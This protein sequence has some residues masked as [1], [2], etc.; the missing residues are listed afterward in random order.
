MIDAT[1]QDTPLTRNIGD[2]NSVPAAIE[3]SYDQDSI[4]ILKGLEAVR[5][6]PGMYIGDT[7]ARGFRHMLSEIFDNSVDEALAGHARNIKVT[8]HADG[9]A[10]VEDDGRGIPV[11]INKEEGVAAATLALTVL[12]AGGKFEEGAYKVSGG[13]HGVGASVVNAL[14]T[15]LQM[16]IKR[17][18]GIYTQTFRDGGIYDKPLA[19]TGSTKEHGTKIHFWPDLSFF[20]DVS[21]FDAANMRDRMR[22]SSYLV[23][24]LAITFNVE[25]MNG[26]EAS[27]DQFFAAEYAEIVDH[28]AGTKFGPAVSAPLSAHGTAETNKGD[29]EVFVAMKYYDS[30]DSLVAGYANNISTPLGGQHVAGFRSALLR[31]INK[32]GEASGL[33]KEP[34]IADDVAEGLVAAIS[35]RL[36]EPRFEAQT[37]ERLTNTEASGA[38]AQITYAAISKYF[39]ENPA[40]AKGIISKA[41]IAAKAREAGRR[42]RETVT[43][44]KTVLNSTSLPGKLAD[45][46]ERNPELAELFIVEGDSAG[47]TAKMGRNSHSQ[48][49]LPLRGKILNVAKS[50]DS[51]SLKSE[52]I[53]NL[54]QAMGCGV[55]GFYNRE[56]L[57]YHKIVIMT[58]ADVDGEHIATL[59]L[60]FFHRF[61]PQL[62]EDGHVYIAM[63]P[64][65]RVKKG[66]ESHYIANDTDLEKF[67]A[68]NDREKWIVNRFKGL[69]EMDAEQLAE[70]TMKPET[71]TMGQIRYGPGGRE[72][73]EGTFMVLMGEEVA[74]RRAFIEKMAR[75]AVVDI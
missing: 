55:Q 18:G 48:A 14:S 47:G 19:K 58:D 49:I 38:V 65:F 56:G 67:F 26:H 62:I 41:V 75:F 8:L 52:Q 54:I 39:E 44:R 2:G 57:R 12:H 61:T 42:A 11:G 25:A 45:C 40:G 74:P 73:S 24:G 3:K 21:G 1:L 53:S 9:S 72:G 4:K 46:R 5:K 43:K 50:D 51:R 66:K 20:E 15:K 69:G 28:L 29:V 6:R 16:T 33:I 71:R 68:T 13:L 32:Y 37:K 63:P 64:L 27:E 36:G 35:V 10:S 34:L 70:T 30:D 17:D 7:S 23:P 59:M 22:E 60:T 31:V